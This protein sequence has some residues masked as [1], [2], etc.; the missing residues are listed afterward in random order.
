MSK[1]ESTVDQKIIELLIDL[2]KDRRTILQLDLDNLNRSYDG[3]NKYKNMKE[4]VNNELNKTTDY[5][6]YF[7][8]ISNNSKKP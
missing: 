2:A 6:E 5:I 1:K 8:N 7:E 3:T 4:F